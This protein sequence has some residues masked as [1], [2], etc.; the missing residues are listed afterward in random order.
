MGETRSLMLHIMRKEQINTGPQ[1]IIL[2]AE[3]T[4]TEGIDV[5]AILGECYGDEIQWFHK[6]VYRVVVKNDFVTGKP[7]LSYSTIDESGKKH[8]F[9]KRGFEVA[10]RTWWRYSHE[11]DPNEYREHCLR[12]LQRV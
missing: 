12:I 10:T 8:T 2:T 11:T 7:N 5:L 6:T 1:G 4:G 3:D 9:H